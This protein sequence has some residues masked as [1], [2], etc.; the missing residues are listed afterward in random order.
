MQK[1]LLLR[2]FVGIVF[3]LS[4]LFNVYFFSQRE[5]RVF[6]WRGPV[7]DSTSEATALADETNAASENG[8]DS[9]QNLFICESYF[10]EY[11]KNFNLEFNQRINSDNLQELLSISPPLSLKVSRYYGSCWRVVGD[12]QP[13]TEYT[14]TIAP[15]LRSESGQATLKVPAL[16]SFTTPPLAPTVQFLTKSLYFPLQSQNFT[17]PIQ[18]GNTKALR[19]KLAKFYENNLNP[20][21]LDSYAAQRRL[22]P[23]SQ[24]EIKVSLPRNE[25]INYSL[26]L[27]CVMKER[28]PGV[29]WLTLHTDDYSGYDSNMLILTDL[30]IQ[31]SL[32]GQNQSAAVFIRSLATGQAV[33][34]AKITLL[35]YKNQLVAEGTSG[36][37][38]EAILSYEPTYKADKGDFVQSIIA[39]KDDDI[40]FYQLTAGH[41][42]S[43]FAN[44]GETHSLGP[45]A[46]VYTERGACR[47]G[48]NI[49]IFVFVRQRAT[50]KLTPL[51]NSPCEIL[52]TDPSNAELTKHR[53][54]LDEYGFGSLVLPL[55]GSAR[56]GAYSIKCGLAQGT[57]FA[58]WGAGSFLVATYVPD[59]I[60]VNLQAS[61]SEA[62]SKDSLSFQLAANYY[63]GAE[64]T[65]GKYSFVLRTAPAIPPPHW[66]GYQVGDSSQFVKADISK[67]VW[68]DFQPGIEL[69]WDGFQ[70]SGGKSYNP[71]L[72]VATASV[73]EPGGRAV[74]ANADVIVH[75]ADFYL[76]LRKQA[77]KTS[78]MAQKTARIE[79]KLLGPHPDSEI[80]VT[81]RHFTKRLY[82]IDWDYVLKK[83]DQ[84][85]YFREWARTH[86]AV[87]QAEVQVLTTS[88]GYIDYE[89]LPNGCYQLVVESEDQLCQ[90]KLE[91]WHWAGEGGSRS[92]NPAIL[93]LK[94][95]RDEYRPG[96]QATVTF[97][98]PGDGNAFLVCGEM[99]L[100]KMLSFP[101]KAGENSL[102]LP[103]SAEVLTG[104]YFAGITLVCQN[105]GYNR[106]FA[107]LRLSINQRDRHHLR[108]TL[109]ISSKTT[110]GAT[111]DYQLTVRSEDE[112]PQPA[113][114]HLFA[115]DEGIL[116]LTDYQT[117]DIFEFFF[118]KY[119][120]HFQFS[121]IYEQIYPD[122]KI[123]RDGKIGGGADSARVRKLQELKQE[124][125]AIVNLGLLTVPASGI[126]SGQ[127]TLPEHLGAM[128][129]M[130][131]ATNIDA[132]G[133]TEA[134]IILRDVISVTGTA[135]R[136]VAP[137]DIFSLTF[138]VFNHDL[139]AGPATL[140]VTIPE[141]WKKLSETVF[142]TTLGTAESQSF[143]VKCQAP[144][145]SGDLLVTYELTQGTVVK[146]GKLPLTI[147]PLN[148]PL[149]KVKYGIVNPG[150]T[151]TICTALADDWPRLDAAQLKVLPSPLLGV[152]QALAWLNAYP[153]GC[154]EQIT[155]AAFPF[156]AIADLHRAGLISEAQQ[157]NSI[158]KLHTSI[159]RILSMRTSDGQ[160]TMW[161]GGYEPWQEASIF[162]CHFLFAAEEGG[163]FN[164]PAKTTESLLEA[165]RKTAEN[166]QRP[167]AE[168]GYAIY[169]WSLHRNQECL[170]NA[171]NLLSDGKRDFGA[172]FAAMALLRCGQAAE[173]AVHLKDILKKD[174]WYE[175]D[176]PYQ[177][178]DNATRAGLVLYLLSRNMADP[179]LGLKLALQ[180]QEQLRQDD[181]GWGSTQANAWATLGLAA[182]GAKFASK[183]SKGE[184]RFSDGRHI[185]LPAQQC[186][187]QSVNPTTT[188]TLHNTGQGPLYY[189]LTVTGIPKEMP[190][191]HG[192]LSLHK[193]Y[194]NSEGQPVAHAQHGDLLTVQLQIESPKAMTNL[195]FC[196]L[197]PG[198]LEIEDEMLSSRAA[199]VPPSE[200]QKYRLLRPN[201]WENHTDRFLL[202]ADCLDAGKDVFTYR[203][204]A[205][206]HGIFKIP[207]V[208]GEAMYKA[209]FYGYSQEND[210][211][212]IH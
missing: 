187:E 24:A 72:V 36:P 91:F 59:R 119:Y 142:T 33:P 26:D 129:L 99:S 103:I 97:S 92:A 193:T 100:D 46:F 77:A 29:Y 105:P 132:V 127:L 141:N 96:E 106:N 112:Q 32:D 68:Q 107:L 42:L 81:E 7:G 114:V 51:A 22:Q 16:L 166:R 52:V 5:G 197:L 185:P 205:V 70:A 83:N 162:A 108:L 14:L 53:L 73:L 3:A 172:F 148:P 2:V 118:G 90:S 34:G 39:K 155:A 71:V 183:D 169:V 206:S 207:P 35:S 190:P 94:T 116:A 156:L 136:A 62:K 87:S 57:D 109:E 41:S 208:H 145:D 4:L 78:A 139:P 74:S 93:T 56:T 140:K 181:K 80:P 200:A 27:S 125:P 188:V 175:K 170:K 198:G 89:N 126:L 55:V 117:P 69:Q 134:Q 49:Q 164:L 65:G 165:L 60:K 135:P 150:E 204:R 184:L 44:H 163:V 202:F 21:T 122:L 85:V 48:E 130:A 75:P 203:V 1:K 201:Y 177:F 211:F 50:G 63:F 23:Q 194:L 179:D 8:E 174:I 67:Q 20:F 10:S 195:I 146:T 161:P 64:I 37:Q 176:A 84:G 110:P 182:F 121:D 123:G 212:I 210:D 143:K 82:Q 61:Q 111:L 11:S 25:L 9:D 149:S 133:K 40:S 54:T 128:R 79:L 115:V 12:F 58:E 38:G 160:F 144:D 209:D 151:A 147:R 152:D 98:S 15:G 186:L 120:C 196:D 66:Q 113:A 45:K 28:T 131:V 31:A 88:S 76:G 192:Q 158:N 191:R 95:D 101:V 180:L 157:A 86:Q 173:G 6:T 102:A 171:R 17:L 137:Q 19:V 178:A 138:N 153:Y 167:R 30:A 154:L 199:A 104:S 43:S 189:Q 124:T 18:I 159:N 13:E 47:P 168:R